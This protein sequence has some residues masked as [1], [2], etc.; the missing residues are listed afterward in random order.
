MI[1]DLETANALREAL[2]EEVARHQFAA[3]SWPVIARHQSSRPW[4]RTRANQLAPAVAA[5]AIAA[6]LVV[7]LIAGRPGTSQSVGG[8]QV[9]RHDSWLTKE[10]VLRLPG[11]GHGIIQLA[12]GYGA[13]WVGGLGVTYRV[14]PATDRIVDTISTPK[15]GRFSQ[16]ATGLGSAWVSSSN[17]NGTGLGIYRIDPRRDRVTAFIPLPGTGRPA[18]LAAAYGSVWATSTTRHGSVLRIDPKTGQVVGQPILVTASVPRAIVAGFGRLWVNA[19]G[20]N[21]PVTL[22]NPATGKVIEGPAWAKI[23]DVSAVGDGS[24][25]TIGDNTVQRVNPATGKVTA[26]VSLARPAQVMFVRGVAVVI[27]TPMAS[28]V[29]HADVHSFELHTATC[30]DP[31]T[32]KLACH[33][34]QL[35]GLPAFLTTAPD[36]LWSINLTFRTLTHYT[37]TAPRS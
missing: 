18:S 35:G 19:K 14:D 29:P 23:T 34:V 12:A 16:V 26:S 7:V 11:T 24:L 20:V 5:V 17:P 10:S 2:D 27:T 8:P 9:Q 25:W 31:A 32:S 33:P 1:D 3:D 6:A 15:A 21:A 22:I 13:I 4:W 30:I 37:V 28:V 36:G